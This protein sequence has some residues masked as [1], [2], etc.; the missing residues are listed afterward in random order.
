M[1]TAARFGRWA[2]VFA[3]EQP[4]T[5]GENA[6]YAAASFYY[7][8]ATALLG[9]GQDATDDI[10][11]AEVCDLSLRSTHPYRFPSSSR[12]SVDGTQRICGC[13]PEPRSGWEA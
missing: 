9:L 10:A 11:A 1:L 7:A 8:R 12:L 2:D 13:W 4:S 5:W 6:A 3:E